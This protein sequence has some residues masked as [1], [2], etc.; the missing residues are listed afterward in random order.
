MTIARFTPRGILSSAVSRAV[1][2]AEA[3]HQGS[4]RNARWSALA[5]ADQRRQRDEVDR[6]LEEYQRDFHARRTDPA[7]E[8]AWVAG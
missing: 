7:H 1:A 2:W 6:F 8:V 4:C 5:M 3:S